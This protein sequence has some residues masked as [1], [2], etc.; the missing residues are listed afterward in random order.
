MDCSLKSRDRFEYDILVNCITLAILSAS[1]ELLPEL[2][3]SHVLQNL[4][5]KFCAA[6]YGNRR[7]GGGWFE[8]HVQQRMDSSFV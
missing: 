4:Q 6:L 1:T 2:Q 8:G 3:K 7:C 5:E